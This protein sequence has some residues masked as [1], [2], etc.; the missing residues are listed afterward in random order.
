MELAFSGVKS[1]KA[2]IHSFLR[3]RDDLRLSPPSVYIRAMSKPPLRN[4]YD[5]FLRQLKSGGRSNMYGAV[6]YLMKAFGLDR[7]SAFQVVCD[8][9]DQQAMHD[10][11]ESPRASAKKAEIKRG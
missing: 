10:V 3:L 11:S 1:A 9:L 6:P 7:E 8:W 5:R 4:P 2:H